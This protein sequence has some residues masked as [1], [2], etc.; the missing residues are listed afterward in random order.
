MRTT[1]EQVLRL[2]AER[3]RGRSLEVAAMK[4]GM[5]RN[6][7]RKYLG[8]PL[9]SERLVERTW[10]TREDPF[11][12][13]WPEMAAMLEDAPDLEAQGVRSSTSRGFG[14]GAIRTGTFGPF[15]AG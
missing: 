1:D 4:A 5:H 7:A 8:G 3:A 10:R 15:S 2:R 13:D 9:P 6:T 12:E 14:R 11:A